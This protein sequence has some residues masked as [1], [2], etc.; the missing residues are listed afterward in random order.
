MTDPRDHARY[1]DWDGAYVLGALSPAERRE[2]EQHLETCER[3]RQAVG[4]LSGMPGLLGR[5]DA[6]RAF[7]LLDDPAEADV[8]PTMAPDA[9]APAAAPIDLVDRIER[10]E[11]RRRT[12][13]LR[14]IAAVAAVAVIASAVTVPAV[15]LSQH[16]PDR[17][18]ALV[19]TT[20]SP[21]SAEIQL[22]S[23]KWGTRLD[24]DCAYGADNDWAN[25]SD[26]GDWDY[27]LWVVGRDGQASQISTW[28][29]T[30]GSRV[31]LSAAT[32][33]P[34]DRI[35]TVEVRSAATGDVLLS[36]RL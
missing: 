23:V 15:L 10:A 5:V 11:R 34:L 22:T 36:K 17:T 18:V 7:G 3:C 14:I 31:R 26:E 30:S 20:T 24:M 1:A 29:A 9:S 6:E 19:A 27:T 32:A 12:R 4:E 13:R 25:P 28:N 21:L 2:Y 33:L 16:L 8:A 35:A